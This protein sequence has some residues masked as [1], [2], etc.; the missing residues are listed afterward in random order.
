MNESTQLVRLSTIRAGE[1]CLRA[2]HEIEI[3]RQARRTTFVH[4]VSGEL[5]GARVQLDRKLLVRR[6]DE[7]ES[8]QR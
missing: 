7:S 3:E 4:V 8:A 6:L 1:R 5:K 2:G